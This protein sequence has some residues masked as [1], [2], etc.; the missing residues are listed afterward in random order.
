M[1]ISATRLPARRRAHEVGDAV[2]P[3]LEVR[4]SRIGGAPTDN[5]LLET[6]DARGQP[7]LRLPASPRIDPRDEVPL[8][9]G[10][11]E[12]RGGLPGGGGA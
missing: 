11:L 4:P 7:E 5:P 2:R 8:V 6:E 12:F 9:E 10:V 3:A 1:G